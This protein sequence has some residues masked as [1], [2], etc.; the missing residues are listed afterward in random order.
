MISAL[1]SDLRLAVRSLARA[2]GY[3][4]TVTVVL[5]MALGAATAVY[6]AVDA[7]LLNPVPWK[8]PDRLVMVFER[9]PA[10]PEMSISYPDFRDW[11]ERSRSW[12]ALGGFQPMS[13]DVGGGGG[14]PP[15]HV[16]AFRFSAGVLPALGVQ[17]AMGRNFLA[18]EDRQG[19]APVALLAHDF[20]KRRGADPEIVGKAIRING[21]PHTV[22]GVLPRS[23]R[24]FGEKE[25]AVVTPLGQLPKG[26]FEARGSHPGIRAIGR[27]APGVTFEHAR[28]EM[29]EIGRGL[30][31]EFPQAG[32]FGQIDV[33]PALRPLKE[34]LVQDVRTAILLLLGAVGFVVLVAVANVSSLTLA[35]GLA[36]RKEL[37][38][39]AALGAGRGAL[40]RQLLVESVLVALCGGAVGLLVAVWG[41]DLLSAARPASL[42]DLV[43]IGVSVPV[44]LFALGLSVFAG[45][46]SGLLPAISLSEPALHDVLKSGDLGA[47][48]G[49][50][51]RRARAALVVLEVALAFVLLAG[52]TTSGRALMRLQAKDPGFEPRNLLTF[53]L[54]LPS[55]KY[56]TVERLQA[57]RVAALE[58][59][60]AV[61]GVKQ[62]AI[63]YGLPMQ[64]SAEMSFDI[65]GRPPAQGNDMPFAVMYPQSP[66]FIETLRI[67]LLS[68]R[69]I[70][71]HD[72]ARA[73]KVVV[74]DEVTARKFFP[75]D[76]PI[77]QRITNTGGQESWEIVG[78]AKHVA[79]YGLTGKEPSPYQLH[80]A[81]AQD[82]DE[83]SLTYYREMSVVL[84]TDGPP[85]GV[86]QA[87]RAA[88]AEVEPD[89]PIFE[90]EP[91][92]QIV[93][94][95]LA[96]QRFSAALLSGFGVFALVLAGVG[97]F[98]LV[99]HGVTRR[100]RELGVRIALGAPPESVQRMVVVDGLR[101]VVIGLVLGMAGAFALAGVLGHLVPG[102]GRIDVPVAVG[103]GVALA[104]VALLASWLP[105][106]RAV[107]IDPAVALR[108]E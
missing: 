46:L 16:D 23:F 54:S 106:R 67:P 60:G 7:V 8:D 28:S 40:V 44:L 38:I 37:A 2:P 45:V 31:R 103:S 15:E 24:F 42:P 39:R 20:W 21:Q 12:S 92:Q 52:A 55:T 71:P 98:G 34:D 99:S 95:S 74:I 18:E 19:A 107:R 83:S 80:F 5:G 3:A 61:P 70:G 49:S 17:P 66:G 86:A 108:A 90:V 9:Q 91:M 33:L 30:M 105:A 75:N 13:F 101:P 11:T 100:T 87:A 76:D 89:A 68:G 79:A 53:W 6:S 41:V 56:T 88:L 32:D 96:A 10:L 14:T 77:G 65:A 57:F 58:R 48:A 64:G 82:T 94:R 85:L 104:A 102:A 36:R 63:A 78:V 22:V 59:L 84:R 73:P 69:S 43:E 72:D 1:A 93:A 51:G 4:V 50:G 25:L 27:L 62:A 81:L 26:Q 35:R 97:L 47:S 29:E